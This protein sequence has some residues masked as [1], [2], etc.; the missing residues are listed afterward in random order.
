MQATPPPP[1]PTRPGWPST[2][3]GRPSINRW[4]WGLLWLPVGALSL[5][6]AGCTVWRLG[7]TRALTSASQ[8]YQQQPAQPVL[9]LLVLGDSTAVGTGASDSRRSVA[10]LLGQAHPRLRID[11][12]ARDG[13]RLGEV[14]AQLAAALRQAGA[15]DADMRWDVILISAGG[16]DVIRG[17]APAQLAADLD[18]ALVAARARLRPG[19]LLLL[20]PPGNVGNAPFFLPPL[21]GLMSQRALALQAAAQAAAARH[22]AQYVNLFKPPEEDPFV[23]RPG[24]NASDGLH[25]SDAG[26]QVWHEELLAQ[27]G[28]AARLAAAR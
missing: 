9:A 10:G 8:P 4:W 3:P 22:G 25:P 15:A 7:E 13:A 11:N 24:L 26:Y 1:K 12:Q 20:Q 28:L 21:A 14:P 6:V 5:G 16:N 23:Q 2:R 27:T 19:G 18:A 17:S